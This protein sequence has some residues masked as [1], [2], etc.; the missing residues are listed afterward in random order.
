MNSNDLRLLVG[1]GNPGSRYKGTRH[2]IG[3]MALEK[4]AKQNS[5]QFNLSKKLFGKTA[6]IGI[7]EDLQRL[8]LPNT[9]MNESGRSIRAAM[10]W[11]GLKNDQILILVDDMDLPLGKLRI[12][13]QGG[14]G[15]H[16]GLQSAINHLGTE[17]FCRLR[18]GIGAP[19]TNP[20][21][22]KEKTI[23]HVLGTFSPKEYLIVD[24]VIE[25]V[26]QSLDLIKQ[27]GL[28]R[29]SNQINSYKKEFL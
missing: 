22:R 9:F 8:L 29:A 10:K 6:E 14:S 20:E 3:F 2:N 4:F 19:A 28:E 16:K 21:E 17:S 26:I 24:E 13:A 11:F 27:I 23:S 7:G 25:M 5:V 18:I 12:R 15:G 1:L